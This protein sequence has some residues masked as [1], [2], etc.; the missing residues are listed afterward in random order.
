MY[1][2]LYNTRECSLKPRYCPKLGIDLGMSA[3]AFKLR[4]V[5]KIPHRVRPIFSKRLDDIV[6]PFYVVWGLYNISF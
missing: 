3:Q 6:V 4:F 5:N 1:S 2:F